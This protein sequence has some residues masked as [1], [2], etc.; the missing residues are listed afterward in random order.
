MDEP[1]EIVFD[2]L[3]P[4]PAYEA[5]IREKSK[6]LE[7]FYDHIIDARVIVTKPERR[8]QKGNLFHVTL[9]VNV[10]GQRLVVSKS[11]GDENRHNQLDMTINDAFKAMVRQLEDYN[12]KQR[13]DI[14]HHDQP[15]EGRVVRLNGLQGFG[16]VELNN[17]NEVYFHRNSVIGKGFEPLEVGTPV[18]VVLAY[19]E[20]P[21]GPQ[22]TTVEQIGEMEYSPKA[23]AQA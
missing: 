19:D 11:P 12:R 10:P 23:S 21:E 1:L 9:E 6:K 4:S 22:A 7:R 15:L 3:D 16:F 20:S 14:K 5:M 8:H 2:S 17:G 13:G 18:R